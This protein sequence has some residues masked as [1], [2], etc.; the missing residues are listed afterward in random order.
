MQSL[1]YDPTPFEIELMPGIVIKVASPT[2]FDFEICRVRARGLVDDIEKSVE[3]CDKLNLIREGVEDYADPSAKQALF[4][5]FYGIELGKRLITDFM[6]GIVDQDDNPVP[7]SNESV[8][9]LLSDPI[10]LTSFTHELRLK[11]I[12]RILAKKGSGT[13]PSGILPADAVPNTARVVKSQTQPAQEVLQGKT[14]SDAPT[15]KPDQIA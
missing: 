3:I 14:D 11:Q 2:V 10:V 13:G 12:A 7:V 9:M 4:E 15:S 5:T 8:G 1:K 6:S